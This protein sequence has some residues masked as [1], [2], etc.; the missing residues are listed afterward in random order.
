MKDRF[1]IEP[2]AMP[3]KQNESQSGSTGE[4]DAPGDKVPI[5]EWGPWQQPRDTEAVEGVSPEKLLKET[6]IPEQGRVNDRRLS[7]GDMRSIDGKKSPSPCSRSDDSHVLSSGPQAG[8]HESESPPHDPGSERTFIKSRSD[9]RQSSS[10]PMQPVY[11]PDSRVPSEGLGGQGQ[12]ADLGPKPLPPEPVSPSSRVLPFEAYV[13]QL[14]G[15]GDDVEMQDELVEDCWGDAPIEEASVADMHRQV[16][17]AW[18]DRARNYLEV[19]DSS[20]PPGAAASPSELS[21]RYTELQVP[22]SPPGG[23]P[24]S[25]HG[26]SYLNFGITGAIRPT[27]GGLDGA[28][29]H[30]D[31]PHVASTKQYK[32][33]PG[34]FQPPIN[35]DASDTTAWVRPHLQAQP[36]PPQ[37]GSRLWPGQKRSRQADAPGQ[38]QEP[39]VDFAQF[40]R[41]V[42]RSRPDSDDHVPEYL[43]EPFMKV[44]EDQGEESARVFLRNMKSRED[45][46]LQSWRQSGNSSATRKSAHGTRL[47]SRKFAPPTIVPSTPRPSRRGQ[48]REQRI[49]I[50]S[51]FHPSENDPNGGILAFGRLETPNGAV[52]AEDP[53]AYGIT[54]IRNAR[55]VRVMRSSSSRARSDDDQS[56]ALNRHVIDIH[57]DDDL[58]GAAEVGAPVEKFRRLMSSSPLAGRGIRGSRVAAGSQIGLCTPGGFSGGMTR[59]AAVDDGDVKVVREREMARQRA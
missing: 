54:E 28:V 36:L 18:E 1:P 20:S 48:G 10:P 50:D 33:T 12:A 39:V 23:G 22:G 21:F 44:L 42:R 4:E 58:A 19:I 16:S 11:G 37:T 25:E 57:I 30:R 6:P 31:S 17:T 49:S 55:G 59:G 15:S 32:T 26:H 52:I 7:E 45:R 5:E 51:I 56:P 43:M 8:T 13:P 41:P 40:V 14:D 34:L 53:S 24:S 29:E 9:D 47:A 27:A 3:R 2:D 38:E 46:P 35:V